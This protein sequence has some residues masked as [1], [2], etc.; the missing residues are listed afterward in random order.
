M[1]LAYSALLL[2]AVGSSLERLGRVPPLSWAA[3]AEAWAFA[4]LVT[5]ATVLLLVALAVVLAWG[6]L[7]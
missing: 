2:W 4:L 3:V 5:A 7:G 1:V 6:E